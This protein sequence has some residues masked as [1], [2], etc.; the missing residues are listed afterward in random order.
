[1][2]IRWPNAMVSSGG[3]TVLRNVIQDPY[4]NY[5]FWICEITERRVQQFGYNAV[6][7]KMSTA[8]AF[9]AGQNK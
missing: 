1:M 3:S 2:R 6:R 5:T 8:N 4:I 9:V 7:A